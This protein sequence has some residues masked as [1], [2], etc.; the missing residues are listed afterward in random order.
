VAAIAAGADGLMVEMHPRPD[1]ALSDAA[2]TIDAA[3]LQ[4]LATQAHS[5]RAAL[6]AAQSLDQPTQSPAKIRQPAARLG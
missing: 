5:V 4:A 1:E 6:L 2:Q 3:T